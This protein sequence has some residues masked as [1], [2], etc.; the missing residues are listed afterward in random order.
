MLSTT[1]S[2]KLS[3]RPLKSFILLSKTVKKE[4]KILVKNMLR[5]TLILTKFPHEKNRRLLSQ[6]VTSRS[7]V[8]FFRYLSAWFCPFAH[9]A[10]IALEHHKSRVSYEWVE[11]LGWEKR[12]NRDGI[13]GTDH[14]W[15][16]HWKSEELTKYNPSALVPTLIDQTDRYR[17]CVGIF[18]TEFPT[19]NFILTDIFAVRSMNR[20]C[21]WIL[22]TK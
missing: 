21:V 22:S 7:T 11:A 6:A 8:P 16:Y 1:R 4:R 9:R 17:K 19:F 10:T 15:W 2:G 5:S 12:P 13:T 14:E 18:T 3:I 20:W